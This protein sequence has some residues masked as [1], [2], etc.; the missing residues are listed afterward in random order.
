MLA[1]TSTSSIC[2]DG[3]VSLDEPSQCPGAADAIVRRRN[4]SKWN[5]SEQKEQKARCKAAEE[6]TLR[7]VCTIPEKDAAR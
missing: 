5:N 6:K 3:W 2:E 1:S 4:E 7:S